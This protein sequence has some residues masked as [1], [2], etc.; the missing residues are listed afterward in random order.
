MKNSKALDRQFLDIRFKVF[1]GIQKKSI[2]IDHLAFD[3][4][5][6]TQTFLE[7]FSRRIDNF[8]FYLQALSLVEH[9]EG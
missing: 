8:Y 3:L 4:G 5:V 9:W 7:Y 2:N 6:D 1:E